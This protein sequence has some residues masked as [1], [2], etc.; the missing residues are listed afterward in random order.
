MAVLL[1]PVVLLTER[2]R[3]RWPCCRRRGV[4]QERSSTVGRVQVPVVLLKKRSRA[5]GRIIGPVV[6]P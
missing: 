3:R 5:G 2:L 4:A 1:L 6:L